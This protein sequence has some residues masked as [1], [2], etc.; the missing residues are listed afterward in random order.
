MRPRYAILIAAACVYI[1]G[2]YAPFGH[3]ILYPL[4]LFTTWV[5]ELGHGLSALAV[6]GRFESLDIYSDASG[7]AFAYGE[8]GWREGIV[9]AGGLLAPPIVGSALI[10][11]VHG[12]RRAR[13]VLAVLAA[14]LVASLV[15]YVRSATGLVAMPIVAVALAFTAWRGFADHPYHRVVA[16][17]VLGVVLALDTLTRM[18][19]YVFE[20]EVVIGGVKRPSDIHLVAENFGGHYLLWGLAITALAVGL[21]G[22]STWWAWSRSPVRHGLRSKHGRAST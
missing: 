3:Y 19:S 9:A 20:D 18:V 13:V 15:V 8:P 10:A 14:A 2:A 17:Q 5:H 7:L 16:V 6:G 12:P 11:F 21:L 1:V 22:L 4:T